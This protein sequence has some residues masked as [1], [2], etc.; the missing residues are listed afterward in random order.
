M[1]AMLREMHA[2]SQRKTRMDPFTPN[3]RA[4]H[5]EPVV[6]NQSCVEWLDGGEIRGSVARLVNISRGGALLVTEVPPPWGMTLWVR[7]IE[8]T[9]TDEVKATVVRHG[10]SHEVGLSFPGSCPFDLHLAATLG[11]N[12]FLDLARE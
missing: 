1:L 12:P 3:R 10:E 4:S 9:G 8:P 5:R 2:A 11:I 6:A 7:M